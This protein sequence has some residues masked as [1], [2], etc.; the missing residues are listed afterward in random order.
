MFSQLK[1]DYRESIIRHWH[2]NM[3]DRLMVIDMANIAMEVLC[4]DPHEAR[5]LKDAEL[6]D[7]KLD[8]MSP[9]FPNQGDFTGYPTFQIRNP[10]IANL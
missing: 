7:P 2:R 9:R 3:Y 1:Q 10:Y 5:F 4:D 8:I 6:L